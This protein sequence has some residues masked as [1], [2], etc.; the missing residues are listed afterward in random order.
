[1]VWI[2]LPPTVSLYWFLLS[3]FKHTMSAQLVE[4]EIRQ[5]LGFVSL[6]NLSS[7]V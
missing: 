1:M 2:P 6:T 5:L 3:F 4:R 7:W